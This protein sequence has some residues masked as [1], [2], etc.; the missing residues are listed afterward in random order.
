MAAT[1]IDSPTRK[2]VQA[3]PS[4]RVMLWPL[5]LTVVLALGALVCTATGAAAVPMPVAAVSEI[6]VPLMF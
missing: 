6:E 5:K 4:V 3:L 2:P 1:E